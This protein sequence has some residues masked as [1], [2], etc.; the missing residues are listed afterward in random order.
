MIMAKPPKWQGGQSTPKGKLLFD[1]YHISQELI[2]L[3]QDSCKLGIQDADSKFDQIQSI[4]LDYKKSIIYQTIDQL[5][6]KYYS[7]DCLEGNNNAN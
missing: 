6:E 5:Y 1:L 4:I 7:P 3:Q 2:Q